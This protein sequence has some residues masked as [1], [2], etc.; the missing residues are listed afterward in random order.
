MPRASPRRETAVLAARPPPRCWQNAL[1]GLYLQA[2]G[3]PFE[4]PP[5]PG[6]PEMRALEAFF[7]ALHGE[8]VSC[9]APRGYG[10]H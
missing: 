1:E 5:A 8:S 10:H 3:E 9:F 7:E 6:L 2:M 4:R